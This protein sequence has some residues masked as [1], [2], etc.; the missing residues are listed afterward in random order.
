[1]TVIQSQVGILSQ[2]RHANVVGFMNWY[3]SSLAELLYIYIYIYIH[4]IV[5]MCI[6]IYIYIY[7][8][9]PSAL[10]V[11]ARPGLQTW[12]CE[13]LRVAEESDRYIHW[14]PQVFSREAWPGASQEAATG[15][16]GPRAM[17][18]PTAA[19]VSCAALAH[20]TI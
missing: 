7:I 10:S 17:P 19:L 9:A 13:C 15:P 4:I 2:Y 11:E 20:N 8:T 16:K 3:E 5:V 6:Y 1:M 12:T 18:F 14:D